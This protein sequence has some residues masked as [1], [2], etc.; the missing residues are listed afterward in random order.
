[1]F[2]LTIDDNLGLALVEPSFAPLYLQIISKQRDYLS[3]WLAWPPHAHDEAFFLS[4]VERSLG[5]YADG[6]SMVCAMVY[7]GQV[8]G[9]VSFNKIN[10][11][12]KRVE[13]GYWLD[14]D[15]QGKGIVSRSVA[16][17]TEFAFTEL[18]MEK[19]QISAATGNQPSRNVCERLG[20]KLEGII[21][22]NENLNGRI[23]DHAIY[24]LSRESWQ[25]GS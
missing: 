16:K 22:R 4:F 9:N 20:F 1:M 25:M 21:T 23:V 2:T 6:K 10:Q 17:L 14:A 7:Q 18:A 13:I 15:Y 19:V 24:G 8:V 11:Q 12:L 5:E 3:Q